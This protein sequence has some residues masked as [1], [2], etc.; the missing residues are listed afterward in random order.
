MF[1]L[2][3]QYEYLKMTQEYYHKQKTART[4]D[5]HFNDDDALIV[6]KQG[7]HIT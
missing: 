6:S 4:Y 2:Y 1:M 3:P 7:C 5:Y